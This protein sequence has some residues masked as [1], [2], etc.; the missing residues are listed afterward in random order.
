MDAWQKKMYLKIHEVIHNKEK[1]GVRVGRIRYEVKTLVARDGGATL[2]YVDYLGMRFIEQ[3]PNKDSTGGALA[4]AGA[5]LTQIYRGGEWVGKIL[6]GSI[7][8]K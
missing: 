4:R 1:K 5:N 6:N 8:M 2:R 7:Q 3:N